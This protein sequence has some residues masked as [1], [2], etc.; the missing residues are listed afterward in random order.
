MRLEVTKHN[1]K[2]AGCIS[3]SKRWLD[4]L[5]EL[6]P[7]KS[8]PRKPKNSRK[9]A[10]GDSCWPY[11]HDDID[12]SW[13]REAIRH[14]EPTILAAYL[15]QANEQADEIDPGVRRELAEMLNPASDHTWRLDV[16]YRPLGKPTKEAKHAKSVFNEVTV[17]LTELLSGTGP[18]DPRCPRALADMLDPDSRYP[19]RLD[20]KQRKRGRPPLAPPRKYGMGLLAPPIETDPTML[21]VRRAERIRGAKDSGPKVLHKQLHDDQNRS[22]YFRYLKL[23]R[24]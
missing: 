10:V 20:F 1:R 19:L 3:L 2:A 22:K 21:L 13:A 17:K 6:Q 11:V 24:S 5:K 8:P 4:W 23:L 9:T 18:L 16:G 14:G 7:E 15:R 12:R